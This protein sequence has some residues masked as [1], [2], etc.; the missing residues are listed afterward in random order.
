MLTGAVFFRKNS[1]KQ[2][3]NSGNF[4]VLLAAKSSETQDFRRKPEIGR[5]KFP[6]KTAKT[7]KPLWGSPFTG[8]NKKAGKD[9]PLR[10]FRQNKAEAAV[11]ASPIG[12]FRL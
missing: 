8:R 6:A 5:C 2:R 12:R 10:L 11:S 7:A 4:A 9:L 1:R 3:K